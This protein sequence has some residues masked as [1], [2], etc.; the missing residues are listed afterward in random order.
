MNT[1][2]KIFIIKTKVALMNIILEDTDIQEK[3]TKST[4]KSQVKNTKDNPLQPYLTTKIK[5]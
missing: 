4:P 2:K 3:E 1:E 5:L